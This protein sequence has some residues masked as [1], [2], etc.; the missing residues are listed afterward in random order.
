ML[1][2]SRVLEIYFASCYEQKPGE[3]G[4]RTHPPSQAYIDFYTVTLQFLKEVSEEDI[5][6]L[7]QNLIFLDAFSTRNH[8]NFHLQEK[9]FTVLERYQLPKDNKFGTS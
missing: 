5:H 3:A 4:A 9:I 2:V 8:E 1:V 6:F 7:L